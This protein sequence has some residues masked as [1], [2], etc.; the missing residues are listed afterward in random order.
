MGNL[1]QKSPALGA[2]E[3][4]SVFLVIKPVCC[5]GGRQEM[6]EA[7]SRSSAHVLFGRWVSVYQPCRG[8]ALPP[9]SVS[10]SK[11]WLQPVRIGE[12]PKPSF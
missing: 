8:T 10:Q 12:G 9:S 7:L 6:S 4:L 3:L 1:A 11:P 5:V 2:A